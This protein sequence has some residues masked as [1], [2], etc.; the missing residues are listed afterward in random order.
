MFGIARMLLCVLNASRIKQSDVMTPS[1]EELAD[2]QKACERLEAFQRSCHPLFLIVISGVG[3]WNAFARGGWKAALGM[4]VL[5]AMIMAVGIY[6]FLRLKKQAR[7]AAIFLK[8]LKARYGEQVYSDIQKCPHS[9]SY[10]IFQRR[11]PPFNRQ[12]VKLP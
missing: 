2:G 6:Q 3:I 4:A 12:S 7:E 10:H 9:L 5:W 8:S 1:A 11:F